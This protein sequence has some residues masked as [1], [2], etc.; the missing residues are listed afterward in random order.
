MQAG[1]LSYLQKDVNS[2]QLVVA[3]RA[4]YR[5]QR[6]LS[7]EATQAL[8][9]AATRPPTTTYQLSERE[10]EVLHYIV[11]GLN[12]GEIAEKMFISRSTVKFHVNAILTKLGAQSR[13]EAVVRATRAGLLTL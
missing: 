3:I 4:A 11:A 13:T 9:K 6:T 12:N 1:A 10:K 7:S 2:E 5:G 8:I